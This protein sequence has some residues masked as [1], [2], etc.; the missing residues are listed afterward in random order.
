MNTK[1]LS[2]CVAAL[3]MLLPALAVASVPVAHCRQGDKAESGLQGQTTQ[4]EIASG[5]VTK[6]FNCNTDMVG[7][8]QGEGASWQLTAWKNCAYFDQRLATADLQNPGTVAVDVSDPAHPKATA[9]LNDNAMLDPW[10]S[11]KVNPQRQLLA[12]AQRPSTGV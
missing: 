1:M 9:W 10:E 3:A 5:A 11:L 6:G 2:S 4:A 12:A 7:Q 8:Y